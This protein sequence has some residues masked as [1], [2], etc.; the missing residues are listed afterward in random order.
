MATTTK[1]ARGDIWLI[2]FDPKEGAEIGK[3]RPAV[4]INDDAIGRLPL[5]IVVPVTDWRSKY[6]RW[7]WF[8]KLTQT[9]ENGLNKDSG[10]DAFQVK[11]LA[12]TRFVRKLG[13]VTPHKP[14]TLPLRLL[15]A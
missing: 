7:P 3:T 6:E 11:S 13:S 2:R 14:K 5:S 12:H 1:P 10:A 9:P 8:V 4:V 15:Y